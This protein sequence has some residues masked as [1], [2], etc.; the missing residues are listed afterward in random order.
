MEPPI[1]SQWVG[2]AGDNLSG[3]SSSEEGGG[4]A[5]WGL[6]LQPVQPDV[7]CGQSWAESSDTQQVLGSCSVWSAPPQTPIG[8]G[9]KSVDALKR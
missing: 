5:L 7:R 4:H 9:Y 6:S 8:I 1:C 2:S 3:L